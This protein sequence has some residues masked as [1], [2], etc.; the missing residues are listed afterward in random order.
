MIQTNTIRQILLVEDDNKDAELILSAL[1]EIKLM[2]KIDRSK[3]GAEAIKYL[4]D[5]A[6]LSNNG[7]N[8]PAV[9]LLDLKMPKVS[10]LEVLKHIRESEH[11]HFLPVV[12]LTSS[13]EEQDLVNSYRLHVNA[14][15]VKPLDIQQFVAAVKEIGAFWALFNEQPNGGQ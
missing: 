11:L 5:K 13:K 14:Y 8:L 3:D 7:K 10:G 15:V 12:I 2:N 9:I 4:E 1:Q 6:K